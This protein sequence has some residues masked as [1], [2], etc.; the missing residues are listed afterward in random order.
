MLF[1]I[2][3][4]ASIGFL[5]LVLADTLLLDRMLESGSTIGGL[6]TADVI[7]AAF[8]LVLAAAALVSVAAGTRGGFGK[9]MRDLASWCLLMLAVVAGYSY[10]EEILTLGHRVV[11]ELAPPGTVFRAETQSDLERAVRIRRGRDGHF[12]ANTEINGVGLSMLV[13]TGASTVVLR[14]QDAQKLGIDPAKL[15]Y[16]VAV[17]TANGTTYAA[18]VRLKAF[19]VGSI[20]FTDVDALVSKPGALRDSLLGMTFL[21][22]LRSYEFSGEYLTLRI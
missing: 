11:G 12:V 1:W 6:Q 8:G 14:P 5:G 9:A 20:V 18:P 4:A 21:N 13:D 10:R 3:L 2:V 16:S 15:R 19:A 17:Q 22:R 7:A